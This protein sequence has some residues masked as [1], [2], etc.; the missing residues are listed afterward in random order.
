MYPSEMDWLL[1]IALLYAL[2]CSIPVVAGYGWTALQWGTPVRPSRADIS[3]MI[4]EIAAHA[5]I[6]FLLLFGWWP[7]S[8]TRK[9]RQKDLAESP[10][11]DAIRN[12]VVLVHGYGL[13]RACWT[14]FQTYLHTRGWEWVWAINHRPRSSPI[15]VYAKR[16]GRAIERLRD[17]TG[18]DKVDLVCHSMGGIVAAYA[19]KEFGYA[20]YVRR[21]ITLGTPWSGTKTHIFG[22][23][24][25][26]ADMSPDSEVIRT[27][28]D[29][30]G[31]TIAIWSR[32]DHLMVPLE[33]A[34][35]DHAHTIE[36]KH[37]GHLEMVT[38]ARV[39][40]VVADALQTVE[41][42]PSEE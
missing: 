1:T 19:L 36:M 24:R 18:A 10:R 40:R 31:D 37:L 35:P 17:E 39:F 25:E 21:M 26:A 41:P 3:W 32:H 12:P 14:F 27:L 16:L 28:A 29:F 4:R 8:P 30:Q 23:M 42:E 7:K 2:S 13:N 34:A 15:P 20:K 38:S 33:S 6:F 9:R 22:W 5:L 11:S